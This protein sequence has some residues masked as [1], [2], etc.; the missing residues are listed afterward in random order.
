MNEIEFQEVFAP[1]LDLLIE[2]FETKGIPVAIALTSCTAYIVAGAASLEL[3]D[4][5][6]KSILKKMFLQ[7]KNTQSLG[8][9]GND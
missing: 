9:I 4:E 8:E 3:T 6:F 7:F 1:T 5:T 2:F